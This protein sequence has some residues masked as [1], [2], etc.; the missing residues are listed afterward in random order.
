MD[1]VTN[2]NATVV[3]T[4]V[5]TTDWRS[6]ISDGSRTQVAKEKKPTKVMMNMTFHMTYPGFRATVMAKYALQNCAPLM[7]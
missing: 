6:P 5:N 4:N 7:S 3:R 2:L 1:I